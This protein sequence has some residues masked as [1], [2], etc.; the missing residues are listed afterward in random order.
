MLLTGSVNRSILRLGIHWFLT[1]ARSLEKR[2]PLLNSLRILMAAQSPL[3]RVWVTLIS[4]LF[5][6]VDAEELR[7]QDVI[8][9]I[10]R[11]LL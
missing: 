5:V 11:L 10:W 1:H 2:L 9:F 6:L 3:L 4:L 8:S 7:R